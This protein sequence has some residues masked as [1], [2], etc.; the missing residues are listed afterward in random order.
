MSIPTK[1]PFVARFD[2]IWIQAR[3]VQIVQALCWAILAALAGIALVAV[4]DYSWELPYRLR[5]AAI[6][7]TGAA[8]LAL[9]AQYGEAGPE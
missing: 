2:R 9:L 6:I 8:A 7:A 5:L 1:S 3:R 4:V